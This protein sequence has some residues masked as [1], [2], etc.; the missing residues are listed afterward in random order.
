MDQ[1]RLRARELR[2]SPTHIERL[3]WNRLR[4]WQIDGFKFRRQQPLGNYIA[5]FVCFER[6]LI[7]EIDGGQHAAKKEYDAK[8]DSWLH[9]RFIVLRFWNSD[10]V[11]NMEGVLQSILDNLR[12][13]PFLSPSP[14]GGRRRTK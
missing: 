1:T 2:R 3:L 6:R 10:I 12:S 7:V 8:R 4:F 9:D 14:Q 13:T 5:D 11:E